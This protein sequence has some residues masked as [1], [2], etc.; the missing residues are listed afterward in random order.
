MTQEWRS[1]EE[2]FSNSVKLE[3]AEAMGEEI[4]PFSVNISS[5]LKTKL[6]T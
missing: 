4:P 1:Y 2:S 5:F 3:F 6:K